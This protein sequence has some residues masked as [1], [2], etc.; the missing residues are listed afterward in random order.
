[1]TVIDIHTHMFSRSW[2][3]Q[4]RR[5]GDERYEFRIN[6]EGVESVF[7]YGAQFLTPLPGHFD[8]GMRVKRMDEVGV[9]ISV[10]SLTAPN[11]FFGGEEASDAAGRAINDDMAGAQRDFPDRIRWMASLPWEYPDAAVA[12][13]RRAHALG[14][15]GV[16]VLANIRG[17]HLT[18]ELFAPVWAEV[19]RLA[20]PVLVH[21][22]TPPGSDALG[23]DEFVL[24]PSVGFMFD[25]SVAISRMIYSG[26]LDRY[27]NLTIIASHAGGALPYLV[28]RLDQCFTRLAD[29]RKAISVKPSEYMRRIA[30]DAVTYH[31]DAL[32]M[33]LDVGGDDKV[34]YGSDYPHKIGDMEGCLERVDMLPP[35]RRRKVRGENARRLFRI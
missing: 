20:L 4:L 9:D 10:V 5:S 11:V 7:S 3:E 22:T 23:L 26:F 2:L 28:G 31:V 35:E 30:Y 1:M 15:V 14:A 17:R 12:E 16:M 19:D 24:T 34:M 18:E 25:T 21:P 33:C 6:S 27:P 29:G 8:Y 32:K 13:L